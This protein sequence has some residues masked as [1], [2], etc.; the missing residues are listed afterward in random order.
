MRERELETRSIVLFLLLL[1]AFL[2]ILILRA[3][4]LA[5]SIRVPLSAL[6][7]R[8]LPRSPP[9]LCRSGRVSD[10]SRIC[11]LAFLTFRS[12]ERV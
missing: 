4:L 5:R 8:F 9:N 12:H 2:A 3:Y 11:S 1:S 6:R 7:R 10:A